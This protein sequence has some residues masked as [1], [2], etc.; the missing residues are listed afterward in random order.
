MA[1]KWTKTVL[2]SRTYI[3][4]NPDQDFCNSISEQFNELSEKTLTQYQN[5]LKLSFPD[6]KIISCRTIPPKDSITKEIFEGVVYYDNLTYVNQQLIYT[7]AYQSI[8]DRR[9]PRRAR[10]V[11]ELSGHNAVRKTKKTRT[12]SSVKRRNTVSVKRNQKRVK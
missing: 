10:R 9:K 4:P 11:V 5:I 3:H 8:I 2:S 7:D 6:A 12:G 1:K